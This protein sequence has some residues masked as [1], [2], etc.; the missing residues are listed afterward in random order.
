MTVQRALELL[1][2]L[3]F[4]SWILAVYL[5][6]KIF[7]SPSLTNA[8]RYPTEQ[9]VQVPDTWND[10]IILQEHTIKELVREAVAEFEEQLAR[11]SQTL[12]AAAS[13]YIERYHREPP[14]GFEMWYGFAVRHESLIID[15]FDIINETLSPFWSLSEADVK[16]RIDDVLEDD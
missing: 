8:A 9:A 13:E 4:A 11:Q 10:T 14:P 1:G 6:F 5:C 3:V 15:D 7:G 2:V 12:E 16:Q